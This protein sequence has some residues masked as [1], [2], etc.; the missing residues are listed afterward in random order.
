MGRAMIIL[1][2]GLLIALGYTFIGTNNQVKR[3][4]ASN[5][6][7]AN[8]MQAKNSAQ[9]AIQVAI[10]NINED[11]NWSENYNSEQTAWI[12]SLLGAETSLWIENVSQ[13]TNDSGLQEETFR[14]NA[15]ANYNGEE[16]SVKTL[17][18]K[19]ELHFVPEFKSVI[20]FSTDNFT[21]LMADSATLSGSDPM[22]SCSDMPGIITTSAA[23]SSQIAGNN[24]GQIQGSPAIKVD[25]DASYT[26]FSELV[27]YLDEMP[28]VI[29]LPG[30]YTGSL[31]DSTS[32][33]VYFV[34]SPVNI[35]S[36]IS[37]GFGI[38]VVRED[39]RLYYKGNTDIADKLTFNGLVIFEDAMDFKA[40]HT[41][42]ISGSV[43]I[44]N[45]GPAPT[46]DVVLDGSIK[47]AY[48]C[49]APKYARKASALIFDQ[50]G[51]RR[52]VTFE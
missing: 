36:D 4:T 6:G 18:K 3:I 32:P 13:T 52:I 26:S 34:D 51:F 48:D 22:G 15:T 17:Y 21:F 33:G 45:T 50:D 44:G 42:S 31:G 14:I 16:A 28:D 12:D 27:S 30:S 41:P 47:I 23:D 11:P 19:S 8:L 7:Y 43:V 39:G 40:D 2:L 9:F 29:H 5:A 46:L 25:E 49:N 20:S 1:C 38:L 10:N 24:N 35:K 37:E